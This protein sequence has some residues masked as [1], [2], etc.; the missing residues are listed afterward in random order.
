MCCETPLQFTITSFE[1]LLRNLLFYYL[2]SIIVNMTIKDQSSPRRIYKNCKHGHLSIEIGF[3]LL[4]S[5]RTKQNKTESL[6]WTLNFSKFMIVYLGHHK[7]DIKNTL[8]HNI[9]RKI[10]EEAGFVLAIPLVAKRVPE[11][12][13]FDWISSCELYSLSAHSALAWE[14]VAV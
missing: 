10:N 8:K 1:I 14:L 13:A 3:K 9:W 12:L 4:Q 6:I 5:Y 2:L 7:T 11:H